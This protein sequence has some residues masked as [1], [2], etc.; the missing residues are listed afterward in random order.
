MS[1]ST[2]LTSTPPLGTQVSPMGVS[3]VP[4]Y[5]W[6]VDV[7]NALEHVQF[8]QEEDPAGLSD[9]L[10][11]F[12]HED[13]KICMESALYFAGGQRKQGAELAEKF[14]KVPAGQGAM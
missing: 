4:K 8:S 11:Q 14:L 6:P 9:L 3:G 5:T 13:S 12:V 1:V 2:I 7:Q 10:G